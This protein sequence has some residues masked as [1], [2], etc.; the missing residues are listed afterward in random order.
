MLLIESPYVNVLDDRDDFRHR[1]VDE[2]SFFHQFDGVIVVVSRYSA[3]TQISALERLGAKSKPKALEH[4]PTYYARNS[5]SNKLEN[6]IRTLPHREK[7][8]TF[9]RKR[10][11]FPF[12]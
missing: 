1:V 2:D 9:S 3:A 5:C 12:L 10:L 4:A 7:A 6:Q 11:A 8:G